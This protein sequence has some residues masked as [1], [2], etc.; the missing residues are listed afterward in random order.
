MFNCGKILV[1]PLE[2]VLVFFFV[3]LASSAQSQITISVNVTNPTCFDHLGVAGGTTGNGV[4]FASAS[5]GSPPYTYTLQSFTAPQNNGY[6]PGLS[7]GPYTVLVNDALGQKSTQ[8][9]NL[10]NTKPQPV[11]QV[12]ILALPTSCTSTDGSFEFAPTGGTPPYTY[13]LDGGNTYQ[14]INPVIA[15]LQQGYYT[16][17]CKDANGCVAGAITNGDPVNFNYFFNSQ[18]QMQMSGAT[19][20]ACSNDGT[21]S[22]WVISGGMSPFQYSLDGINF[23][24]PNNGNQ[25]TITN[26]NPGFYTIYAK[27]AAGS[28]AETLFTISKTCYTQITFIGVNAS[29]GQNDGSLTA[30]A[31]YGTP[32]Y[33]YTIDGINFQTSNV[34]TGLAAGGYTVSA[35]DASG[36]IGSAATL[37]FD[38][39]PTVLAVTTDEVC[40]QQNGT[41]TATGAKGTLPYQFSI[42]G[43]NF[44]A[45]NIFTGLAFGEYVVT[46]KDANGFT[47]STLAF[48]NND[49]IQIGIAQ[50]NTNCGMPNGSITITAANGTGPYQYSIDGINFQVSNVFSSLQAGA[51]TI[52]VKDAAGLT[53]TSVVTLSDSPSPQISATYVPASCQNT[54][55][56]ISILAT[57]GAAPILYSDDGGIDFQTGNLFMNLDS[58]Q[59]SIQ[60]RD[61]NGCVT[62]TVESVSALPTPAVNLGNDT[63]LCEGT[64]LILNAGQ[65]PQIRYLWQDNSTADQFDVNTS[66][67]YWV[68]LT[69]EFNCSARDTINILYKPIPKFTLGNDTVLCNKKVLTINEGVPGS[70]YLWNTGSTSSS[71][72]IQQAGLYWLQVDEAGC[73][74]RDSI[75]ISVKPSPVIDIGKD[76]TLCTGQT[77]ILSAANSNA[78]YLWQDGSEQSDFSV[79]EAGR[80]TVKVDINGCDTTGVITVKYDDKPIVNLGNDT[81]IC[82]TQKLLLDASYPQA[83]YQWQDGSTGSQFLVSTAGQYSV[84]ISNRCGTMN[85]SVIVKYE[86]CA[87][88]VSV[89]NAFTPNNDGINDIFKPKFICSLSNYSS[90]IFNRWGQLIFESHDMSQGW[91]GYFQNQPQ[92]SGTYVWVIQYQDLFTGKLVRKQGTVVLIR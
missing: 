84:Q 88:Q 26:I 91:D 76:T 12:N 57:G 36:E 10:T 40:G 81:T 7:Q 72:S 33:T 71:I 41:V 68:R 13:S 21:F 47:G 60:V 61:A 24:S 42:D 32:P 6:F 34:F 1:R 29:C 48:V 79:M 85:Q 45:G 53:N 59:Y 89:P 15:N 73:L 23:Q 74:W 25:F 77:L 4:I 28:I 82:I 51:F 63:T 86:N 27:D 18:C 80:Y 14:A 78:T 50:L 49:C 67:R 75:S 3:L 35:R 62:K 69:N 31:N 5:G 19:S 58:G 37:V 66:G 38:K 39:C 83:T 43:V 92:P 56:S 52:T 87:C 46:I 17:Y 54:G 44:Q 30:T 65:G 70:N 9:I 11:L 90:K 64:L 55:G 16:L 22:A 20:T 2:I 8:L